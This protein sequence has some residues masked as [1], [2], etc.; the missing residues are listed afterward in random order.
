MSSGQVKT[1]A[2]QCLSVSYLSGVQERACQVTW[3]HV[4]ATAA[5]TIN[6]LAMDSFLILS[7]SLY[8]LSLSCTVHPDLGSSSF[9]S[10]CLIRL[11]FVRSQ[12]SVSLT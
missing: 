9:A 1:K 8:L 4:Y 11:R 6:S 12:K 10:T 3:R 2:S 5:A 7:K